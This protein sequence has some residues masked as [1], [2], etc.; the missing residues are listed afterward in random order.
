MRKFKD[1]VELKISFGAHVDESKQLPKI[2][3]WKIKHLELRLEAN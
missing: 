3:W 2:T 1:V